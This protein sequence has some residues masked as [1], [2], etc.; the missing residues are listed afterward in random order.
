MRCARSS[1]GGG[2]DASLAKSSEDDLSQGARLLKRAIDKKRAV[3][4]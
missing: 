3:A 1:I 2:L 4:S